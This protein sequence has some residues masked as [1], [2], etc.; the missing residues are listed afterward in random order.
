MSIDTEVILQRLS[1]IVLPALRNGEIPATDLRE[2]A[3][4]RGFSSTWTGFLYYMARVEGV[5]SRHKDESFKGC[6]AGQTFY[7]LG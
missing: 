6:K 1:K 2:I 5:K 7:R 4:K 3:L